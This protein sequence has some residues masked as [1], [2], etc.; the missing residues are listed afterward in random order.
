MSSV[1]VFFSEAGFDS[2]PF[3]DPG[4]REAYTELGRRLR[5]KGVEYFLFRDPATYLG[6][7][8][9][10]RGWRFT[11]ESFEETN[12]FVHVD[13]IYNKGSKLVPDASSNVL[14]KRELD[15]V[16]RDKMRTLELFPELFPRTMLA[17]NEEEALA[18]LGYM[19]TSM[20]VLKP[21][22]G[23]GGKAVWIGP[24]D[25][26]KN[27]LEPYPVMIQEFIDTSKGIPGYPD[28]KH[29]FRIVVMNGKPLFTFLRVPAEGK[30]IA[31]VGKGGHV[32]VVPP[33]RRPQEALDLIPVVDAQF[34]RFGNRMYSID[35]ARDVS[36][37][38]KLIELNDQPGIMTIEECAE[39]VDTYY[40]TLSDFL[41][42][43]VRA[44]A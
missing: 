30:L 22:D 25:D 17:R 11:G 20:V 26:A 5:A 9:F 36:G 12:D 10:S 21:A 4:Y 31:N 19:K 40:E 41:L 44:K 23:W 7:D 15:V 34:E 24:A 37:A 3:D 32:I 39:H 29:D 28:I 2:Y 13:L 38:W 6:D 43:C 8:L 16:C 18:A 42:S 33:D 27:H 1:G 35:C 14:N